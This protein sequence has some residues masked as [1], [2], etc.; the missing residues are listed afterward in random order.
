MRDLLHH[1]FYPLEENNHRAKLLHHSS[2]FSVIAFLLVGQ[3]LLSFGKTHFPSVLGEKIDISS[4][5]L[6]L[7]T[8]NKRQ[9]DSISPL[10]LNVDLSKAAYLKAQDMFAKG[11]WAHTSP[12]G[13]TPWYYFKTVGYDYTYAGENLARGFNT[14][15]SVVDAWMASPTHRENVLSRSY[16]EVGFAIVQGKLSG[17]DTTLVVE[18]FGGKN[19]HP[20]AAKSPRAIP[21]TSPPLLT[22]N[23]AAVSSET[24]IDSSM[25]SKNIAFLILIF[26]IVA[27]IFDMLI[28]ERKKIVRFVGHNVDHIAFL[29]MLLFLIMLISKGVILQ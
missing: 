20:L 15:S 26:F 18:M 10:T 3:F 29:G 9:Q 7:F 5:E 28:V 1:F 25:F 2:I 16:E 22:K 6:L 14:S 19:Q 27:F 8:N 21:T 17:E 24:L 13:V 4:Q 12:D 11:Y 23:V